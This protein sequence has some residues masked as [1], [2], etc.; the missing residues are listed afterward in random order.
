MIHYI[1]SPPIPSRPFAIHQDCFLPL[2]LARPK[3]RHGADWL[4]VT[5]SQAAA[6]LRI[7][8]LWDNEIAAILRV[9]KQWPSSLDD[10]AD[11]Q[12]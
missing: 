5:K 3:F 2:D 6:A 7:K 8:G 11:G 4:W 9:S 1:D 10:L 12:Y